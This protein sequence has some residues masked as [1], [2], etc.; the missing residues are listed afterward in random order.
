MDGS[1]LKTH[2]LANQPLMKE[3]PMLMEH[4]LDMETVILTNRTVVRRFREKDGTPF[5]QLVQDNYRRLNDHFSQMVQLIHSAS[6]AEWYVRQLL[7]R[8]LTLEGF[9]FAIWEKEQAAIIGFVQISEIEW[10]VPKGAINFFIDRNF[11]NQGMMSEVLTHLLP[12]AYHQLGMEKLTARPPMDNYA[13]Q[14]L[15]RKAGF[16][17]EGDLRADYR[18]PTGDLVDVMLFGLTRSSF[19]KV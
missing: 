17:R 6:Q 13:S 16:Q 5:Y 7:A 1:S 11:E 3:A 10:H 4:L 14:R 2:Y 12:F 19:E 9:H 8:W 18:R 15:L